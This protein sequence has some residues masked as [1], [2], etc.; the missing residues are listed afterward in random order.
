MCRPRFDAH[1]G[2][3]VAVGER[4]LVAAVRGDRIGIEQR[5]LRDPGE[6][7][8]LLQVLLS[9]LCG[10][11]LFKIRNR[12]VP[13]GT[14][15]G[16][17]IV[18][19]ILAWGPGVDEQLAGTRVVV[20]HH[21][22]CGSCRL[23]RAG[24]GTLCS[25]FRENLLEPGGFSDLVLVRPR[26]VARALYPIPDPI[27]DRAAIAL[28]PTACVLRGIRRSGL[29]DPSQD[30]ARVLILGAGSMGLLHLLVLRALLPETEVTV[31]DPVEER[32][33]WA[34]RLGA[35]RFLAPSEIEP[36]FDGEAPDVVFDT[37]GGAP[38]LRDSIG[39]VRPG[40][41][42]ILFAHA[43]A[44]EQGEFD[45][46]ELFR[47][48]VRIVPTYSGLLEDQRDAHA[49]LCARRFDPASLVTDV[50]P[51]SEFEEGL[52]RAENHEALKVAYRPAGKETEE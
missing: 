32:R 14:V 18:G 2:Y 44:G 36:G 42:V 35:F 8:V 29:L 7:E 34:G 27:D 43:S 47:N 38:L 22:A 13:D 26:A 50:I 46:N 37:V 21:V 24:N 11:D 51:L 31:V 16:H 41:T 6:G 48:E 40:G 28:E 9:G 23:C 5:S 17:E 15:L 4:A 52:R 1:P 25:T 19:K 39:T 3:D 33:Q 20:P 49:L 12:A 30:A 10:T 45:L